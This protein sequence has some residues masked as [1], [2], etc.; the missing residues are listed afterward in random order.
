MALIAIAA[1]FVHRMISVVFAAA[2]R[3]A[4]KSREVFVLTEETAIR[5]NPACCG[6]NAGRFR[7]VVHDDLLLSRQDFVLAAMAADF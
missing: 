5:R 6:L 7:R 3:G 1:Y 4:A 2:M